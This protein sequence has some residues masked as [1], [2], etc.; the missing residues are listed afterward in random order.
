MHHM[1]SPGD[2]WPSAVV[3]HRGKGKGSKRTYEPTKECMAVVSSDGIIGHANCSNCNLSIDPWDNYCKHC[4]AHI[5][6]RV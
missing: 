2:D 5:D 1:L 3:V 4:G 6:G